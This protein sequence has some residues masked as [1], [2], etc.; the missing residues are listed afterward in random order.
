NSGI[1]GIFNDGQYDSRTPVEIGDTILNSGG[2]TVTI[3]N[4]SGGKIISRGYNLSSDNSSGVLTNATD[5]VGNPML[6]SLQDNGGPI[7]THAL[8]P[9]SPAID[10]GKNFNG[11]AT[12][13]RGFP[14]TN[15]DLSLTNA[16]GGDGT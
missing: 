10:N 11:I 15:D 14:R 1:A 12:D 3:T 5:Q 9:G 4:H 16:T 2:S 7:L 8:L 6:G 13:Q